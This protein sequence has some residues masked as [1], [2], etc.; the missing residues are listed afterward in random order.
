MEFENVIKE[1]MSVRRFKN[2]EI[3]SEK[4][5]KIL[6]A[7]RLAPTAK[8]LQPQKIF[9]IQTK[10]NLAKID[11]ASPCRY[12]AP[13]VLLVCSDKTKCFSKPDFSSYEMDA[14]IVA[15]QMMLEATNLGLGSIWIELFDAQ[16]LK[17]HFNLGENLVPVCLM[18]IGY[19]ADDYIS[20]VNYLNRKDLSEMVEY[21]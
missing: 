11:D 6:E 19:K 16:K 1:R 21:L 15:T 14:S 18:P 10:E 20:S 4:L 12:G 9:V 7:G 13:T 17:N 8:N 2:T 3:E 5:T